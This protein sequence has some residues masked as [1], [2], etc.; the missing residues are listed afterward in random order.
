MSDVTGNI[1]ATLLSLGSEIR[2]GLVRLYGHGQGGSIKAW[3]KE[4]QEIRKDIEHKEEEQA[5]ATGN[6]KKAHQQALPESS[7]D[8]KAEAAE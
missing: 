8:D 1:A 5:K 2:R 7:Q 4:S 6:F 3:N